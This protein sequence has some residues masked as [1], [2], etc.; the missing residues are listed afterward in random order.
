[1]GNLGIDIALGF[2][3]KN[4]GVV[5]EVTKD[6]KSLEEALEFLISFMVIPFVLMRQD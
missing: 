2:V 1:M 5:K 3:L 6:F 4:A